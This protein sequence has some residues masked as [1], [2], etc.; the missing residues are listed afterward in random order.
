LKRKAIITGF[1]ETVNWRFRF[2]IKRMFWFELS[3]TKFLLKV[4]RFY[5]RLAQSVCLLERLGGRGMRQIREREK[6]R[7]NDRQTDRQIDRY[8]KREIER[9]TKE[10]MRGRERQIEK[11]R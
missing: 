6:E 5:E 7:K 4:R 10:R 2:D 3:E 1:G 8:G 9:Y 11:M